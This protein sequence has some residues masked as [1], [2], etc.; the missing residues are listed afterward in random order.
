MYDYVFIITEQ[1]DLK[2]NN[3]CVTIKINK[4]S[5]QRLELHRFKTID[6]RSL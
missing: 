1:Q 5:Y 3:L 2:S 4:K 6:N